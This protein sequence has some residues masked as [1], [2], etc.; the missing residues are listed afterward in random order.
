[1]DLAPLTIAYLA[2][3]ALV[4]AT[5]HSVGGF[6]GAL[7]MAIAFAPAVGVKATVPIVAV[8]MVVSHASRAWLFRSAVDWPVF[9]II[10]FCALPTI[11][12]GVL[13]YVDLSEMAVA[14]FLG[15]LLLITLPLR[16]YLADRQI[17]VPRAALAGVAIPYGFLSGASFGVA[18][19]L[20]PFLLGAGLAGEALV[21]TLA[22]NGFLLN[23]IKS[24][25]FGLSPLLTL[26]YAIL[27]AG[28]GLCTIPGHR[29]GRWIVRRTPL[30]VHTLVLEAFILLGALYF[31]T[32]GLSS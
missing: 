1:M 13:F 8:A 24:V 19:M 26:D 21:G 30:R 29:L 5:L 9:R 28:L 32:K 27:G 2:A 7:M 12:A 23:V 4:T 14:L 31:L 11:I 17:E 10:F 20:G 25:A 22:V 16:R 18:M 15:A 3:A 6:A